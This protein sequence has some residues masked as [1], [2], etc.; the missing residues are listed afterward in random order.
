MKRGNS[1]GPCRV[2]RIETNADEFDAGVTAFEVSHDRHL[3]GGITEIVAVERTEQT[4]ANYTSLAHGAVSAAAPG[5]RMP[6]THITA[7]I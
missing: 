2:R 4:D 6:C 7:D 5:G 1:V 3:C